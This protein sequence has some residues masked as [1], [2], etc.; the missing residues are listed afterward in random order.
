MRLA[1][2]A[3]GAP[4]QRLRKAAFAREALAHPLL[5]L[6]GSGGARLA[7]LGAVD[8]RVEALV[9]RGAFP[10]G[11]ERPKLADRALPNLGFEL[12][13]LAPAMP[14]KQAPFG[15]RTS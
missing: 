13:T 4:G 6:E 3:F 10:L 2:L 14:H 15:M 11:A 12:G 1:R 5:V 9:A 7:E 8:R